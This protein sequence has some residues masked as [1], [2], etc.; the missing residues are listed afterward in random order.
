[1]IGFGFSQLIYGPL[2]DRYG[3]RKVALF[4]LG[5]FIL[6]SLICVLSNSIETLLAGRLVQGLGIGSAGPISSAIP[7][8][9]F[10]GK[11]LTRAS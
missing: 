7:K 3:R 1:M 8:D 4:G 5:L 11:D 2:A 6:E 10:S 9:I